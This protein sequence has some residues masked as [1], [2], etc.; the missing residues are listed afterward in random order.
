MTT[1][2]V[3]AITSRGQRFLIFIKTAKTRFDKNVSKDQKIH[4]LAGCKL[5]K[6]EQSQTGYFDLLLRCRGINF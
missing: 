2:A 3:T 5:L 6:T 4:R 1:Y